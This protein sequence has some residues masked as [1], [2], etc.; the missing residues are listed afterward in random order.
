ML[1]DNAK[2]DFARRFGE[3]VARHRKR[4]GMTQ[5]ELA[6]R[7]SLHRTAVGQLECGGR[8]ARLDTLIKLGGALGVPPEDLLDG[9]QW[10]PG[11]VAHGEFI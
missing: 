7:A 8:V 6:L 10:S 1:D 3:N 11:E 4:I 9:L 2:N 5:E